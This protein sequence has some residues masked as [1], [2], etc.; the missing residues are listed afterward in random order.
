[1]KLPGDIQLV[2]VNHTILVKE[3]EPVFVNADRERI[4]QV[5]TNFLNNAVKYSPDHKFISVKIEQMKGSVTVS[6]TDK[7]IGI[8][9]DEHKK[10]FERFYRAKANTNTVFS[11]F[12]IGL[13]ICAEI[14][15][16]HS[17]DIG[18]KSEEGKGSVFYF[19]LPWA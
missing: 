19:T 4:A 17:G 10:I 13:Y 7:G 16:R 3:T 18:V 8:R 9:P 14:V 1:M 15:R 12:G 5:I 6:V 2:S 11:G